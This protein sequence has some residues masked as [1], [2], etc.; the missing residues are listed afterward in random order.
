MPV[1]RALIDAVSAMW[2]IPAPGPD[3]LLQHAA[4]VALADLCRD[5]YGGGAKLSFSLYNA[6]HA[7]GLPCHLRGHS[8]WTLGVEEAATRLDVAL[9]RTTAIQRHFCPLDLAD[10]LPSQSKRRVQCALALHHLR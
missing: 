6:L 2:R 7:L 8:E 3:N 1:D 9:S 5:R 10:D 4:F